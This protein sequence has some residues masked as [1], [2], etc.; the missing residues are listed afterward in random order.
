VLGKFETTRTTLATITGSADPAADVLTATLPAGKI[1]ELVPGAGVV[2]VGS[3]FSGLNVV[4]RRDLLLL[5]PDADTANGTCPFV[6]GAGSTPVNT[7]PVATAS[8]GPAAPRPTELVTFDGTQSTDADNDALT[9]AWDFGDGSA[10][11]GV[12]VQHA[13][14]AV[15]TFTATLTVTDGSGAS[16]TSSVPVTVVDNQAPAAAFTTST[17]TPRAK[18]P[19]AFDASGSSDA[20]GDGL[21]YTWDFGDGNTGTGAVLQHAW[22]KS[23]R[24]TVTLTVSDGFGGTDTESLVIRV[25]G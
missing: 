12:T 25:K 15:G 13:F 20:D 7:A 5:V 16:S 6:V 17:T 1:A 8:F 23:G 21:T 14:D 10:G 4:S 22:G 19:V 11:T 18:T 3:N 2:S 24:Y 9:Y